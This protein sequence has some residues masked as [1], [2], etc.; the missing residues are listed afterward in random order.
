VQFYLKILV[1]SMLEK[2]IYQNLSQGWDIDLLLR[3]SQLHDIGKIGIEDSILQKP[4]S[5]TEK[6]FALM[7]QHTTLGVKVIEKIE[8]ASSSCDFLDYAKVFAGT[9]HEKW[10]GTGYPYGLEK[11]TIPLPGRLLSIAD[12]YD[13]L[14]SKRPYKP[15]I[16]HAEAVGIILQE[17]DSYFDPTLIDL[18]LPLSGKFLEVRDTFQDD[19]SRVSETDL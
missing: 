9:H 11:E 4:G 19:I 13:A 5:L 18:F 16:P 6:E 14:T 8:K 17:K 12:V 3:S 1:E 10:D 7:K 15:P 2:G